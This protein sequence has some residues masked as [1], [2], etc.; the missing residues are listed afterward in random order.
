MPR[1][2]AIGTLI[3]ICF[4]LGWAIAGL[5]GL[6]SR[7]RLF[8]FA[9]A[10]LVSV[11]IGGGVLWRLWSLHS[12]APFGGFNGAVYG[13]IVVLESA[14][15]IITAIALQRTGR[16]DYVMPAIAFVVGVH[17]FG[18]GRAMG[19]GEGRIFLWIGALMCISAAGIIYALARSFISPVQS[20]S[21]TGFSCACILWASALSTLF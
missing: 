6:P 17:F 20:R 11:L 19:N 7:W 16:T 8:L 5:R 3:G 12:G 18:L 4:A 9:I 10:I 21:L 14:A 13:W 2:V 15:I 1:G